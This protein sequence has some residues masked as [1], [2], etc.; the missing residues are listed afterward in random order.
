MIQKIFDLSNLPKECTVE[1]I[2]NFDYEFQIYNLSEVRGE[3]VG[4]YSEGKSLKLFR[5]RV[6]GRNLYYKD[7]GNKVAVSTDILWVFNEGRKG[8]ID[9]P[10]L[11][12]L[13][14]I[15]TDYLE[16]QVPFDNETI[17]SGVNKVMPGE[18][19][20]FPDRK[21]EKYW[22]LKFGENK[23][24]KDDLLD[25][26]IDAVN[27]RKELLK[28]GKYT[29]YLSGGIDSSSI[30]ILSNPE[31]S[32]SGFYEHEQYSELDYIK[33]LERRFKPVKIN[34][35]RFY[36]FLPHLPELMPDPMGGLGVIPQLIVAMEAFRGGYHYAFTGEGGDEIF[37][38]YNWNTAVFLLARAVRDVKRDCYMVRY[39]S[40]VDKILQEGFG[41]LVAGLIGR[42]YNKEYQVSRILSIWDKNQP[43]ENNIF[44]INVEIG[45]PAILTVD[46][47]VGIYSSVMPVSPL[48]DYNIIEYVASIS[49]EERTRIPKYLFREAMKG[50]LHDKIR[51]R[52]DKMGFPLPVEE[53]KWP[54]IPE[55]LSSLQKR[56]LVLMDFAITNYKPVIMDRRT[57]ALCNLELICRRLESE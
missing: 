38:G 18:I 12:N 19:V 10:Y 49:P 41:P 14:Y 23:F 47:R 22:S 54:M 4:Y 45:L 2:T 7:M 36:R 9:L 31:E 33:C 17:Y 8:L 11:L 55:L 42:G 5:D 40:M 21:R 20:S 29:S 6:G 25:L 50:I 32:F 51:E 27:W 37:T 13:N 43:V 46:E 39:E 15:N 44:K 53:W 57:W 28:E 34:E 56:C 52:R 48:V 24:N 35:D 1:G 3:F 30:T 16:F 26:I